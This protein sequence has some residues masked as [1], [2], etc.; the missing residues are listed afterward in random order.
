MEQNSSS[1]SVFD[2][3]PKQADTKRRI[4]PDF[5]SGFLVSL[6]ALPLCMG[7][8]SASGFPAIAGI[9]TAG[10]GGALASFLGSS[11][12][13]I[14]G[15]AAG[16]IVITLSCVQELGAGDLILGYHRCL[17][18]GVVA[19]LVQISL[20]FLRTGF[21]GELMPPS[22]VHGMLAAIGVIIISKQ[23]HLLLGVAPEAKEPLALL[24]EIPHSLANLNPEVFLIGLLSLLCLFLIPK[25]K[26]KWLHLV[27]ASVLVI[28][29]GL[30]FSFFF[31]FDV[32]HEYSLFGHHYEMN[33]KFLINL[34]SNMLAGISFPDFS[35]FFSFASFKYILMFSLV[36][37]IESILTV[38]AV[39][40]LDPKKRHS[41][42][43][44]DLFAVG[45]GNLLSS[46]L[47]GL[48][49]I[50]E[51]VRS[52]ANIDNGAQSHW[53]NFYQAMFLL[54]FVCLIP[55]LLHH[56]PIT[57]LAAML[58]YT[59]ARLASPLEFKKVFKIGWDQL[60]LFTSTLLITLASDILT[61][62]FSGLAIKILL[63]RL[64]GVP[65]S[66]FFKAKTSLKKDVDKNVLSME[67]PLVFSNFI[68]VTKM[69][70]I[71]KTEKKPLHLDL[72]RAL[73]ID[74]S[75]RKKLHELEKD[76]KEDFVIYGTDKHRGLSSHNQST[77]IRDPY[78]N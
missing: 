4:S 21:L 71:S 55:G 47:G 37:S 67:G 33:P 42:L 22:V 49:M 7:I 14:K 25:V 10:I 74:H 69:A 38:K 48:P 28:G 5:F 27:P 13:T 58:V 20:S 50:S 18:V 78:K 46:L 68:S 45:A 77:L 8:A 9:I 61:G 54:S 63:H 56:I 64:R 29:I 19:A 6:V 43:D 62:V 41:D 16:L 1:F 35:Q 36:G 57:V 34:P 30:S 26:A 60:L 3:T 66:D 2:K 23:T 11:A 44:K 51:I 70:A 75:V 53:S 39:D 40:S 76:L 17:A 12:L 65:V 72:S 31:N 52:K 59:G 15:P 32:R 24:A 73:V